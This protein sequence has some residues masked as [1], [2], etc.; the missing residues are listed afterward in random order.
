MFL[1]LGYATAMHV[2]KKISNFIVK[3]LFSTNFAVKMEIDS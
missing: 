2:A 3:S 1:P